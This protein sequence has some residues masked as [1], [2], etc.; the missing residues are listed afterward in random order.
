[1]SAYQSDKKKELGH[2]KETRKL[3]CKLANTPM[4]LS[5]KLRS[6]NE[7]LQ[8]MEAGIMISINKLIY[9]P[10]TIL[11]IEFLL[12]VF[13]SMNNP[14]EKYMEAIFKILRYLK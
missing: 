3:V 5:G 14:V 9:H 7:V 4:N 8:L 10:H 11:D 2:L 1:M 6:T 12:S 13:S